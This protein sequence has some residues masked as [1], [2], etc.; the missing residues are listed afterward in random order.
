MLVMFHNIETKIGAYATL[1]RD[2]MRVLI[3]PKQDAKVRQSHVNTR[4]AD[5]DLVTSLC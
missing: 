5:G 4:I 1:Q 2:Q 3:C